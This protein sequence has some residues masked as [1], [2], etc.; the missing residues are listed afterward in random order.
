MD[1]IGGQT[2]EVLLVEDDP[3]DA[4]LVQEA[5]AGTG[6][7]T[8]RCHIAADGESAVQF[9]LRRDEFTGA[10]RP[11]LILLDLNLGGMHGLQVLARLKADEQLKTIP[12][13][14]LT[15]SRHPAD[16][17]QSYAHHASAY[18]VKPVDLD[19]FGRAIN[20][21]DACFL[22]LAEPSPACGDAFIPQ[23]PVPGIQLAASD[24]FAD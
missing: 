20:V 6:D 22:R 21:I 8:V 12:V 15:S 9:L 14:V 18:I 10:P 1:G 17:H 11:R 24:S 4:L 13:V 16:I 2:L 3:G 5:L 7:S 19:D 23:H